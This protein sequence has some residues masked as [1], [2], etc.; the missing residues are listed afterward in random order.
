MRGHVAF[1]GGC[2][3]HG[4]GHSWD[5]QPERQRQPQRRHDQHADGRDRRSHNPTDPRNRQRRHYHDQPFGPVQLRQK[6]QFQG[7]QHV[8]FFF[9][10]FVVVIARF[11]ICARA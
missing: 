5:V 2:R 11:F 6:F 3:G 4:R 1:T 7:E 9:F 10:L 8:S